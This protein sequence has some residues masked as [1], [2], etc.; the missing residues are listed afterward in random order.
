M[1][2][3]L[4]DG[5]TLSALR[6][7]Q[8]KQR[9]HELVQ[10]GHRAPGL[11]VVLVGTDPASSVY[12][13]NKRKACEEVGVLSDFHHLP[14][15][16]SQKKLIKLITKLNKAPEI[17]GILIQLPLPKHINEATIIERIKPAKDVD[18]FHPYNLGR[19]AQRNPLLRPC[20][21]MGI[22]NL[23]EHYQLN[24]KGK[25]A[26]V[27]GASN[28]V[29]RPMSLE[30]LAAGATVTVCHRLTQNLE[31]FVRIAD[32]IV[33]AAGH[34]DVIEVEWLN[35]NQVIIDVGIHRL[36]DGT[37]RG[38]VDFK[39]ARDKVAWITPVPGGVGP[40]TVVSLLENTLMATLMLK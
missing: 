24:V 30:L 23:L 4:I 32:L 38:D 5:K 11:A 34:M 9:V 28:I 19:L 14:E 22:M 15:D 12:V 3:S 39:K 35:E 21:P 10:Q 6:R 7:D 33:V 2:A 31:Q 40:M 13:N 37:I 18:G 36:P 17:D 8:L 1:S 16:I 25:H 26:V 29:G 20:T 27:I